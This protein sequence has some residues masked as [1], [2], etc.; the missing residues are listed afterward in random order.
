MG[1]NDPKNQVNQESS[2]TVTD[3]QIVT[4]RKSPRRSFLTATGAVLA[5]AA[6]IVT[7][8]RAEP[9]EKAG[10]P[11]AKKDAKAADP[12]QKK[13]AGKKAAKSKSGTAKKSGKEGDPDQKKANPDGKQ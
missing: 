8:A 4:E 10:D 9:Q 6:A 1:V 12:D 5:A 11:D 2:R 13:A 7:G 3:D